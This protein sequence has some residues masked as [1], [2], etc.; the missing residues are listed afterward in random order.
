MTR[1]REYVD[2]SLVRALDTGRL[3]EAAHELIELGCNHEQQHQEL[4]LMD[5]KHLFSTHAFAPAYLDR[6]GDELRRG[7]EAA[8]RWRAIPAV[9]SRS[10]TTATASPTTTRA[11][12]TAS[13]S[14]TS[15]SPTAP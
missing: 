11:R 5:I 3:D 12:A 7:A 1:Y 4:L 13:T 10:A 8:R 9:S 2:E 14:R 6:P 15:R